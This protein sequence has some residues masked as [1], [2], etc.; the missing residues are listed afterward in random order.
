MGTLFSSN[1]RIDSSNRIR[2]CPTFGPVQRFG[3][4]SHIQTIRKVTFDPVGDMEVDQKWD[5]K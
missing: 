2:G 1:D 4:D 5:Q 3:G